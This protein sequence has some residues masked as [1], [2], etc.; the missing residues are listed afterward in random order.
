M[1]RRTDV[2]I[3]QEQLF[4]GIKNDGGIGCHRGKKRVED[5]TDQRDRSSGLG[6]LLGQS[7][8]AQAKELVGLGQGV[9]DGAFRK[10]RGWEYLRDR[11]GQGEEKSFCF[12]TNGRVTAPCLRW[13]SWL[14]KYTETTTNTARGRNFLQQPEPP[15]RAGEF[16][17]LRFCDGGGAK[18]AMV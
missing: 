5:Y 2:V 17:H 4:S 8:F 14:V 9:G 12:H 13:R 7:E 1:G 15:S 10:R 16:S 6:H 3:V 18:F 11:H